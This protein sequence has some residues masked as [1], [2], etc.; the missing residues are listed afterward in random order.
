MTMTMTMLACYEIF[1]AVFGRLGIS[2]YTRVPT[3]AFNKLLGDRV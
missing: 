3:F 1:V 2:D